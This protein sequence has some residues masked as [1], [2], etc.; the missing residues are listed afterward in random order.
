MKLHPVVELTSIALSDILEDEEP[1]GKVELIVKDVPFTVD[2]DNL[3]IENTLNGDCDTFVFEDGSI[4]F[5]PFR[6]K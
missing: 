5:A 4:Y 2:F 6:L 1:T 3:M